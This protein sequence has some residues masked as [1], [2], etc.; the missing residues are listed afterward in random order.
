M[1]VW[2]LGGAVG[3][4]VGRKAGGGENESVGASL[5]ASLSNGCYSMLYKLQAGPC[6]VAD[7]WL[8]YCRYYR[9]CFIVRDRLSSG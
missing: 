2:T 8:S 9:D 5:L 6:P 7:H 4:G 3:Q 1:Y